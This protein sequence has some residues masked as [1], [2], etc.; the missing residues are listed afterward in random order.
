M[1]AGDKWCMLQMVRAVEICNTCCSTVFIVLAA[2][3]GM[4]DAHLSNSVTCL[5][6]N[7]L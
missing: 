4:A 3:A 1:G 7:L 2:A 5:A 6:R